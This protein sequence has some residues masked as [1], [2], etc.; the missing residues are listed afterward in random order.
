MLSKIYRIDF[1]QET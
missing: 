1:F